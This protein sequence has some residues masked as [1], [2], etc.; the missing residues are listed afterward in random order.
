[1]TST[2]LNSSSE[3]SPETPPPLSPYHQ[4]DDWSSGELL[5]ALVLGG[6]TLVTIFGNLLLLYLFVKS[7]RALRSPTHRLIASLGFADLLVG[8]GVNPLLITLTFNDWKWN[9]GESACHLAQ[10]GHFWLCATSLLSMMTISIERYLGVRFPLRHKRI[11]TK[12]RVIKVIILIWSMGLALT[13]IPLWI[14]PSIGGEV[15]YCKVNLRPQFALFL[16]LSLF[17]IPQTITA[18]THWQTYRY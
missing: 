12:S 4:N 2:D 8:I 14:W 6:I 11:L 10:H 3:L 9:F 16:S 5:L 17:F 13:S 18:I 7:K 1:M 15:G